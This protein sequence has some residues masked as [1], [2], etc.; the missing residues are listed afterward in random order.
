MWGGKVIKVGVITS[1]PI[2]G[3]FDCQKEQSCLLLCIA[4]R[5]N[6]GLT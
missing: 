5:L 2:E 4:S 6:L 1:G 3:Q